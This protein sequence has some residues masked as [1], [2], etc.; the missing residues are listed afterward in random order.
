MSAELKAMLRVRL[1]AAEGG[2]VTPL[3]IAEIAKE[4]IRWT[5]A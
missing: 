1:D 2:Y 5:G 3:N 4:V